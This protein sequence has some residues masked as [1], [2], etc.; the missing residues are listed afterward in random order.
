MKA[1][2]FKQYGGAPDPTAYTNKLHSA[3]MGRE[4]SV[5]EFALQVERLA[6]L[7]YPEL[8]SDLGDDKQKKVQETLLNRI[9]LE[10]FISGLPP[11]LSRALVERKIHHFQDAVDTAAH[12]EVVNARFLKKATINALHDNST[13]SS[14]DS[15]QAAQG[16]HRFPTTRDTGRYRP[17]PPQMPYWGAY[18]LQRPRRTNAAYPFPPNGQYG[19]YM[20]G[21]WDNQGNST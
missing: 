12:L 20:A 2:L 15:H 8:T 7:S 17:R 6:R 9:V 3:K 5:R 18:E 19:G 13:D 11:L 4:V 16:S 10:Q 21:R 14:P 1:A